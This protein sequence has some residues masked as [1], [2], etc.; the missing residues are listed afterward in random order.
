M[1]LI[2]ITI[3]FLLIALTSAS[4]TALWLSDTELL[5]G[6]LHVDLKLQLFTFQ[7]VV[8]VFKSIDKTEI[9]HYTHFN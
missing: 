2:T 3:P 8:S 9:S 1:K 7:S 5:E 6:Y 4:S